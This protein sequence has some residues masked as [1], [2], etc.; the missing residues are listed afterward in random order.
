MKEV[1]MLCHSFFSDTAP[2]Y[3][4]N[5]LHVYSPSRQLRS[6]S[7]S[8]TLRIPHIKT[9]PITLLLSGILCPMKLDTFSQPL[10]LEQL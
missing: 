3:L 8:R 5:L 4:S 2:V 7:D 10:H 9:F 1:R 6:S